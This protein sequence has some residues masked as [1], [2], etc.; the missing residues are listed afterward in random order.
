MSFGNFDEEQTGKQAKTIMAMLT[1]FFA[2]L[3]FLVLMNALVTV[4]NDI[5]SDQRQKAQA[6]WC[7]KQ[8]EMI[9]E[10]DSNVSWTSRLKSWR[11]LLLRWWQQRSAYAA[12][13][14][15]VAAMARPVRSVVVGLLVALFAALH[16]SLVLVFSVVVLSC[17]RVWQSVMTIWCNT[18]RVDRTV[19]RFAR[20]LIRIHQRKAEKAAMIRR[21]SSVVPLQHSVVG[22]DCRDALVALAKEILGRDKMT[23]RQFQ[24]EISENMFPELS[25]FV[26]DIK[27]PQGIDADGGPK[28]VAKLQRTMD[29]VFRILRRDRRLL[30]DKDEEG[31]LTA[32]KCTAL[33]E[34]LDSFLRNDCGV[35]EADG[36]AA[37]LS[38]IAITSIGKVRSFETEVPRTHARTHACTHARAHARAHT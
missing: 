10:N 30:I 4:L 26:G 5:Y 6:Q 2:I 24:A 31:L 7:F 12:L 18:D 32:P 33:I 27:G 35:G 19:S 11:R 3:V 37:F 13:T 17:S 34:R 1:V 29:F 36:V 8:L 38:I 15:V 16:L 14:T 22:S 9:F 20:A 25:F 28:E 23:L 21:L